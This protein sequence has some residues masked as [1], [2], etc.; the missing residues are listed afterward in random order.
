MHGIEMKLALVGFAGIAAQWLAWRFKIPAIALLLAIGLV[1]GP[2]LGII[3]PAQDFGETYKPVVALAVAIILF[4]GGLTLNFS[5]IRETSVA[6][7]RIILIA[8][9]L[10]WVFGTLAAYYLGGLSFY[11]AAILGAILVVTGPTVIM[12]LLRQANLQPRAAS[13]LRWEAIVN[14]PLG[15]LFAVIA[16]ETFMIVN[17]IHSSQT[18]LR[19]FLIMVVVAVPGTWL[20]GKGI[21]WAFINGQVPEFLKAPVLIAIVIALAAGANMIFKEAGLLAVTVLGITLANSRIASLGEMRRFKETTTVILVSAVF[22]LLSASVK[23]ELF[24]IFGWQV[25]A[26][27]LAVLF[28]VRPV[29]IWIATI[30]TGLN[31]RERALSAF[32]APRGIVAVAIAGLFG[33]DLVEQGVADG[34]AILAYTFAVVAATIILHGF[35]LPAFARALKLRSTERPGV[36]FTGSTPFTVAFAG[37]LQENKIPVL[38]A[39]DNWYRLKRARAENIDTYYGDILSEHAHHH[40]HLSSFAD[41]IAATDNDAYNALVC[42]E[43]GPEI[44]RNHV[45][46]I[47]GRETSKVREELLFTIGGCELLED[48]ASYSQINQ[49]IREGWDFSFVRFTEKYGEDDLRRERGDDASIILWI[50]NNG[51]VLVRG[52]RESMEPSEGSKVL[53]FARS[54]NR[55]EEKVRERRGEEGQEA[56]TAT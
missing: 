32:I 13:L 9:P 38:I 12:P 14:D 28:V 29:A 35:G 43:F 19:D 47:G 36:L 15:A 17:G 37:K 46:Q 40:V 49:R 2:V 42:S 22:I 20:L 25:L 48:N 53:V 27:V 33:A 21:V 10:V 16:F 39:D 41:V 56:A 4:E 30:N 3:V 52:N 51:D 54:K 31:W 6:V 5:E 50:E 1:L 23:P 34:D 44:G 11:P 45:F 7:R 18:V 26:F 24:T 8:G 55:T